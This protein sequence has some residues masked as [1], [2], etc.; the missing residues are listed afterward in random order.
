MLWKETALIAVAVVV[1][2][3]CHFRDGGG[4][5]DLDAARVRA[6]ADVTNGAPS[7]RCQER[8]AGLE[9]VATA[10]AAETIV[11]TGNVTRA[12]LITVTSQ[13][14]NLTPSPFSGFVE[15]HFDAGC[16]GA[17][18][19]EILPK[20]PVEVPGDQAVSL[21]V[22]GQCGDMP[23]GPRTLTATAYDSDGETVLDRVVVTFNLT[24]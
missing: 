2:A 23:L 1:L 16:N 20:Q 10:Y 21:N 13:V 17:P 22:G 15:A 18:S 3:A 4:G 14:Q 7:T 5:G 8:G 6:C 11:N 24:E 19:W 12:Q 9:V